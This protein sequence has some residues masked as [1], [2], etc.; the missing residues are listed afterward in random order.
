MA[1][2]VVL[3]NKIRIFIGLMKMFLCYNIKWLLV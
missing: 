3:K 2:G 1:V